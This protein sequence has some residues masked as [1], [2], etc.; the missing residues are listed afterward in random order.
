MPRLRRSSNRPSASTSLRGNSGRSGRRRWKWRAAAAKR[1]CVSPTQ[2][3]FGS[4]LRRFQLGNASV[5]GLTARPR[6]INLRRGR[7]CSTAHNDRWTS[8]KSITPN[9]ISSWSTMS[10]AC[11][12]RPWLTLA[13][14]V[15]SRMVTGFYI[16][17][18]SARGNRNGVVHRTCDAPQRS[19]VC[20]AWGRRAMAVLG[21]SGP[22]SSRQRQGI[23]RRDA[24]PGVRATSALCPVAGLT[25]AHIAV[26]VARRSRNLRRFRARSRARVKAYPYG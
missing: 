20:K 19:L 17:A 13:I 7:A 11:P 12:S 16:L 9:S 26:S 14:D 4:G 6:W 24:A 22:N 18:R 23:P 3:R 10:S 5:V 8:C 21:T 2:T 1:S 25:A 15:Y